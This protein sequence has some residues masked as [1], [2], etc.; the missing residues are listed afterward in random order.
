MKLRCPA[1]GCG[2]I[3][4]LSATS[5]TGTTVP[6]GGAP[7]TGPGLQPPPPGMTPAQTPLSGAQPAGAQPAG[8]PIASRWTGTEQGTQPQ[9]A[10]ASAPAAARPSFAVAPRLPAPSSG[11]LSAAQAVLMIGLVMVLGARGCDSLGIRNVARLKAK[12]DYE[13]RVFE[14]EYNVVMSGLTRELQAE[15]ITDKQRT[16]VEKRIADLRKSH[17]N[18]KSVREDD[19][20]AM[21]SAADEASSSN[22][23]WGYW[24]ELTFVVGTILLSLGL[25]AVGLGSPGPERYLSLGM[26]GII[27]FSVYVGGIAWFGTAMSQALGIGR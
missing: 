21:Q 12:L 17:E 22:I 26:L 20:N 16:D 19:W 6:L 4:Q 23:V 27:V 11:L 3:F 9:P 1:P 8:D 25:V 5:P 10:P 15:K 2:A 14:N 13:K 24:R 7:A 18:E